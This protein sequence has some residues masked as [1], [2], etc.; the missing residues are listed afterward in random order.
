MS[1]SRFIA[2]FCG[3]A[4]LLV[5]C[6]RDAR[7]ASFQVDPVNVTINAKDTSALLAVRNLGDETVRVQISVFS[8][9]QTLAGEV[10]LGPTHDLV[11]FPSLLT[12]A[13][14]EVRNIRITTASPALIASAT[15]EQ[16]YRLIVEELLPVVK[17]SI[18]TTTVR[19]LTK[20]S[21]PVFLQPP[22]I[23]AIPHVEKL[24]VQGH[25]ATFV[26]TNAGKTHFMARKVRLY[27][28]TPNGQ[29]L[30]DTTVGGWYV[31]AQGTRAYEIQLPAAACANG[32]GITVE[33]D[34]DQG[35]AKQ[36]LD[37]TCRDAS[38]Q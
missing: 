29:T 38:P 9:R 5:C 6:T 13:P 28:S 10:D 22:A 33:V 17:A 12:L 21:I 34:T 3:C 15:V 4:A 35:G 2:L 31:L 30:F 8:W 24:S 25:T 19:V 20:M 14:R 32:A 16:T 37:A 23:Q 18:P 7:A 11:F 27:V 36:H 26:L 1:R